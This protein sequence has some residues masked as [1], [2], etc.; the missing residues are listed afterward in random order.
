MFHKQK[1]T[2]LALLKSD[3]MN[4][5][6]QNSYRFSYNDFLDPA[7]NFTAFACEN[8]DGK[9]EY[10]SLIEKLLHA[11]EGAKIFVEVYGYEEV[12]NEQF[13]YSDTLI[14]YSKL[15]LT[16]IKQIFHE[17]E[18]IF[19]SDIGEVTDFSQPAFLIN[20]DGSLVPAAENSR[21]GYSVYYCWW[22]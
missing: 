19:P 17:P 9:Q 1:E 20:H 15:S 6:Y 14:I 22:D 13:I 5:N 12:N 2:I 16:K 4:R 8:L 21:E 3:Q 18:D 10:I 11:D 7:D